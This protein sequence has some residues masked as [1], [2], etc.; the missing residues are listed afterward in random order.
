MS[1]A[2]ERRPAHAEQAL[3]FARVVAIALPVVLS[4][5]LVPLQGAIDT[6]IIGNLGD[7]TLLAA[8]TLGASA[9][10]LLFSSFNFLQMGVS[11]TTAQALGAS[12]MGRVAN[13]LARALLLAVV[14]A[15]G[16]ILMQRPIVWAV[17]TL[18]DAPEAAAGAAGSYIAIRL[19]GAPF[20]LTNYALMGWFAG[21]ERTRRL[22]ELQ[23]VL[24]VGNVGMTLA[25]VF[26]LGLGIEGIALG[27]VVGHGLALLYGLFRV[28]GRLRE[29]LPKG[30]QPNRARI[31]DAAEFGA[32][33]R[34]NRD[35][36]IRTL[37]LS[38]CFAWITRLSAQ[39]GDLVLAANGILLQFFM[40][41]TAGLDGFAMAAE[42]L[43]GQA[44]GARSARRMHRAA[45]VS[46]IAA[47]VLACSFALVLAVFSMDI[48]R[49]FTNVAEVREIASA[50]VL[51]AALIPIAGVACFQLDGIFVGAAE[52]GAMRDAMIA[53][54]AIF[55]PLGWVMTETIGNHGMWAAVWI[56]LALR[57]LLLGLRYPGLARR[58][59]QGDTAR[60]G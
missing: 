8:V 45:R 25:L 10:S 54:A 41:T 29:I 14:C 20:E 60:Q 16:L 7:A 50:Y 40:V 17:L 57:A 22:F 49:L 2:A 5:A 53:V 36:L 6:A 28:R 47:G 34:L 31:L 19:W 46:S 56:F 13:T 37:L 4:N 52:G 30:W 48:V 33:L 24:S 15:A 38:L 32:L 44:V 58:V 35:I 9:I 42:T 51:W 21:Q 12:N 39:Q 3:G 26:G 23:L 11:G 43:V 18:F 59:A 27:T 55:L 1:A